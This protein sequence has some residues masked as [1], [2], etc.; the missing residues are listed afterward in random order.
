MKKGGKNSGVGHGSVYVYRKGEE[1][2]IQLED[3]GKGFKKSRSEFKPGIGLSSIQQRALMIGAKADINS[4]EGSG[5]IVNLV[6]NQNGYDQN[7]P[8]R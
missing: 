7:R 4:K 1:V 8:G 5:T 2:S 6:F 3:N